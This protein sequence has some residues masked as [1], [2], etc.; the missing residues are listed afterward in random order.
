MLIIN[1][2]IINELDINA[3][4][5]ALGRGWQA[6]ATIGRALHLIV[7]NVGGSWPGV[8]DMS[9][10]GTPGDYTMLLAENEEKNPWGPLQVELGFAKGANVVTAVGAEGTQGI[11]G[12]G[13]DSEGFLRVVSA[14]LAGLE[15]QE[16]PVVLLLIAQDTAAML[17]RD[18]YTKDSIREYIAEHARIPYA[19]YKARFL[20]AGKEAP[21]VLGKLDRNGMVPVPVIDQLLIVVSGGPGEKSMLIPGWGGSKAISKEI[22][23]P[24]NWDELLEEANK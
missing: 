7:N 22:A 4:T 23:L 24:P 17:A 1:G 20:D 3:G 5:N 19:E 11:L 12:I 16:R 8:S 10:F 9:C 6:N 13:W 2:P 15:R 14:H 21:E 18:G